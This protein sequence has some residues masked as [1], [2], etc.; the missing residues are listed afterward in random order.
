MTNALDAK[1]R[2]EQTGDVQEVTPDVVYPSSIKMHDESGA[3]IGQYVTG[4]F[5]SARIVGTGENT[6]RFV[7][8]RLTATNAIATRKKGK[9]YVEA[10]VKE[11]EIVTIFATSRL[12]RALENVAAGSEVFLQYDG[13]KKIEGRKGVPHIWTVKAK[14]GTLSAEDI[15]HIQRVTGAASK[16]QAE[17]AKVNNE[18][19]AQAALAQLAD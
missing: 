17:A 2:F 6:L 3:N 1:K 5:L 4:R 14:P 15:A 8:I 19:E 9:A 16:K 18:A 13:R 10:E 7:D 11:G 12:M